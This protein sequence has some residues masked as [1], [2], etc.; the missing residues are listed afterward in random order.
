MT[1][2]I[3]KPAPK[4]QPKGKRPRCLHC[5]KEL[6]PQFIQAVMPARLRDGRR[7]SE[8]NEWVKAN[9]EEFTGDYGRFRDNLFCGASC[10]YSW[11]VDH[12]PKKKRVA[13]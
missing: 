3:R 11:A 2:N 13:A 10:G 7:L 1:S 12:A 4:P 9:P 5:A 6:E 8:R